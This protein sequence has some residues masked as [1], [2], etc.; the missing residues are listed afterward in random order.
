MIK[1][2]LKILIPLFIIVLLGIYM[3]FSSSKIWANYLYN[4][5]SYYF[6][7]QLIF[8][9]LGIFAM[10]IGYKIDLNK[11]KKIINII[12]I[13]SLILLVLVLIPGVGISRNGSR[14]WFGIG[15]FLFQP[16]ELFKISIVLFMADKLS[17][18]Y[19]QTNKFYKIIVPL[20]LPC[21]I[22]FA[23]IMLQPDFGSGLVIVMSVVIMTMVSKAKFK[24]YLLLGI[25]A[26]CG[27]ILLIMSASYR[28]DR[29]IA[30]IDPWK[31]PLGSGFQII[32]S[33]YAISPGGL[34]GKGFDGSFQKYFYLPE[35]QTDFIFAI[36]AEEFGFIGGAILIV[37]Y[38]YLIDNCYKSAKNSINE[39]A[40]FLKI[41]ITS[42]LAV[43]V[44]INLGVVVGLLPVTGITLPFFSYGGS[45][46][47]IM[48]FS[49]GLIIN[50]SLEEKNNE[51][52]NYR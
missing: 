41:G 20:M 16:S 2:N 1:K 8:L 38:A 42:L 39:F 48:L 6:K 23:L 26:L 51:D 46:L 31:D 34:I 15:D 4:D 22:G 12:L 37:L 44:F 21:L 49:M 17:K 45:S 10:Y 27:F 40:S 18:N 24:N 50:K 19:S 11:I 7:R 14:S 32:Q 47:T 3:V 29:I 52:I 36:Y 28:L 9:I 33:L 25:I 30:F 13:I 43:Q 5:S 35:P